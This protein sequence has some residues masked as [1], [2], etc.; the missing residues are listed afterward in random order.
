MWLN[1]YYSRIRI[2]IF[3]KVITMS[4]WIILKNLVW[5][6][7]DW[8]FYHFL[9]TI[10]CIHPPIYLTYTYLHP[11]YLLIKICLAC[12]FSYLFIYFCCPIFYPIWLIKKTILWLIK[13]ITSQVGHVQIDLSNTT[14]RSNWPNVQM[15]SFPIK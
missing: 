5:A 12:L 14:K 9:T 11:S 4:I 6:H 7:R 15:T 2:L 10:P 1:T 13:K 3:F 8:I